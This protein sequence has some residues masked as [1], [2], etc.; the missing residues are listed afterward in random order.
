M[1]YFSAVEAVMTADIVNLNHFRKQKE[2]AA[3]ERR[4]NANRLRFGVPKREKVKEA[5]RNALE[6]HRLDGMKCERSPP[7][8][9]E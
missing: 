9:E 7:E 4:A 8:R 5:A 2:Q 1:W 6:Q 3:R